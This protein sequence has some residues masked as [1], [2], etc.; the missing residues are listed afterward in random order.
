MVNEQLTLEGI[1]GRPATP[2]DID[3]VAR[4]ISKSA[5]RHRDPVVDEQ[6]V[7]AEVIGRV[8]RPNPSLALSQIAIARSFLQKA[9]NK[10]NKV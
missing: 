2:L 1:G 6:T 5:T 4:E 7:W 9:N 8:S 3:Q 10:V